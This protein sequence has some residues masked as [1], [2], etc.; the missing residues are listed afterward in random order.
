MKELT[1]Y[2]LLLYNFAKL[3]VQNFNELAF[4]FII[5]T[6]LIYIFFRI[7]SILTH[8][9]IREK[10][11]SFKKTYSSVYPKW[12]IMT[13]LMKKRNVSYFNRVILS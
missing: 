1:F 4:P 12:P 13:S 8:T 3:I 11:K 7:L 6:S 10:G 5:M 2:Y 9:H